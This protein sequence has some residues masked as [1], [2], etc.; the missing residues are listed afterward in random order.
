M[1][2]RRII[3]FAFEY[4]LS[5]KKLY[6]ILDVIDYIKSNIEIFDKTNLILMIDAI[7]EHDC[8]NIPHW[9]YFKEFLKEKLNEKNN[10]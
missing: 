4:A 7:D 10:L 8:T 3:F 1:M 6:V 2:N 5:S 9:Y